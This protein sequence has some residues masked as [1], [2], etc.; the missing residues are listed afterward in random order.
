MRTRDA[1]FLA[2]IASSGL[3]ATAAAQD[4][5]RHETKTVRDTW[6]PVGVGVA[7]GGGVA[8]F[9]GPEAQRYAD[10]AGTWEAR[11]TFGTRSFVGVEAAYVGAAQSIDAL[12][13]DGSAMLV[14]TQLEGDLR[15][16]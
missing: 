12:G 16:N 5:Y 1:L 14:S 7:I 9:T 13:L 3:T 2:A 8:G 10:V 4:Y 6:M 15:I 11:L